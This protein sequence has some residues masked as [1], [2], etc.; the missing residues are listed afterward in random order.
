MC[1]I[2]RDNL[3]YAFDML[4][5]LI[6]DTL[7]EEDVRFGNLANENRVPWTFVRSRC[8]VDM[9]NDADIDWHGFIF[10]DSPTDSDLVAVSDFKSNLIET[11]TNVD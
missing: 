3:L 11:G 5:L 1:S 8:D 9:R 10:D 6:K 7:R 4:I 2:L